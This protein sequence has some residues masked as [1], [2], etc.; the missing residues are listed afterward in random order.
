V[1]FVLDPTG[2]AG[3]KSSLEAQLRIRKSLR[4]RFPL[5]PWIDVRSKVATCPPLSSQLDSF[6]CDLPLETSGSS[7]G[8]G[9]PS[10]AITVSSR[11]GEGMDLL[12]I[13]ILRV[14]AELQ[15]KVAWEAQS[16]DSD[17]DCFSESD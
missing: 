15:Q 4:E 11:T 13:E 9:Y 10:S 7:L 16:S 8:E 12:K 6:Q 1:I 17:T 14:A 2:L 5:R 3:E